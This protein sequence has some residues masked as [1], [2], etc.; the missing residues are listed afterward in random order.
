MLIRDLVYFSDKVVLRSVLNFYSQ[1]Y[2]Q[3]YIKRN[4]EISKMEANLITPTPNFK[5]SEIHI[6]KDNNTINTIN[7]R[8][9]DIGQLHI[10]NRPLD[11]IMSKTTTR[12]LRNLMKSKPSH[13]KVKH[14]TKSKTKHDE[15]QLSDKVK[16]IKD[17]EVIDIETITNELW[18]SN[19]IV[20]IDKTT[21]TVILNAPI[22]RTISIYPSKNIIVGC[23][24]VPTVSYEHAD[25]VDYMWCYENTSVGLGGYYVCSTDYIYTPTELVANCRLKLYCTPWTHSTGSSKVYGRSYTFYL[26]GTIAPQVSSQNYDLFTIHIP[27]Y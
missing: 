8:Y 5:E 16:V 11:E 6:Y 27:S 19:M 22:I 4:Q 18:S 1:H 7:L 13:N 2:P 3:V 20:H 26:S 15:I 12:L 23:P 9:V 24:I 21:Y 14:K 25:G 10:M 17:E